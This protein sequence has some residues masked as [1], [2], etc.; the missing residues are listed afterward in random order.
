MYKGTRRSE[1]K[2]TKHTTSTYHVLALGPVEEDRAKLRAEA[3]HHR[4]RSTSFL[5]HV[6]EVQTLKEFPAG[7]CF[8]YHAIRYVETDGSDGVQKVPAISYETVVNG[9]EST[10]EVFIPTRM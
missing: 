4:S 2:G 10:G 7:T 1:E 6:Y 5:A 3:C 9:E 8:A